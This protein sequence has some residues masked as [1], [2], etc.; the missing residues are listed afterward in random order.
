MN[1]MIISTTVSKLDRGFVYAYHWL[2][3]DLH[4]SR[5]EALRLLWAARCLKR[6]D[7]MRCIRS[8]ERR[9]EF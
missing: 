5:Y 8:W 2:R 4:Y 3:Y 7:E 6:H 9:E 1:T